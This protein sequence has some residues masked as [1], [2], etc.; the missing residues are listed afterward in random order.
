M[1]MAGLVCQEP[2]PEDRRRL[3]IYPTALLTISAAEEYSE[4][5]GGVTA[6]DQIPANAPATTPPNSPLSSPASDETEE[7]PSAPSLKAVKAGYTHLLHQQKE[8]AA[9]LD[10]QTVPLEQRKARLAEFNDLTAR[11]NQVIEQIKGLGYPMSSSEIC[12]GFDG[13]L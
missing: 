9:Y 1:E 12:S 7:P 11:L 13:N 2:D 6:D 10:D 3:L 8:L 4:S 5:D